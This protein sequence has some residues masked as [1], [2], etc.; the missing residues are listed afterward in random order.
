M[1]IDEIERNTHKNSS[2]NIFSFK[3]YKIVKNHYPTK[4]KDKI[5]YNV[6]FLPFAPDFA[7]F[8]SFKRKY[9]WTSIFVCVFLYVSSI[10][11]SGFEK[12]H[13]S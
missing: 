8:V 1:W 10:Y 7:K 9:V 3:R 2:P 6:V 11:I 4:E 13:N 5:A 12:I